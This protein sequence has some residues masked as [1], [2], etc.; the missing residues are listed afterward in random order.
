[1]AIKR[2]HIYLDEKATVVCEQLKTVTGESYSKIITSLLIQKGI[3][4][5]IIE[6]KENRDSIFGDS[7][8][9]YEF[10]QQQTRF[11]SM[12]SSTRREIAESNEQTERYIRSLETII[13]DMRK[14]Y[15][16]M[17]DVMNSY[18]QYSLFNEEELFKSADI[19][20][21]ECDLHLI[22][23]K[24]RENY[25]KMQERLRVEKENDAR[26]SRYL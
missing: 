26:R 21:P 15:Y 19:N 25:E 23:R 9:E 7:K 17:L 13:K 16:I 1:M 18:L 4:S 11:E 10:T 20:L 5:G 2:V 14:Q 6:V 22:I 3:E 24:S 8:T 12:L